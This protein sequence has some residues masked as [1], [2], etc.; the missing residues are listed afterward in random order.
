MA[1]LYS[2]LAQFRKWM[3]P[4]RDLPFEKAMLE[5]EPGFSLALP[6]LSQDKDKQ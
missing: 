5:P 3:K 2:L 4:Y 1:A 6:G